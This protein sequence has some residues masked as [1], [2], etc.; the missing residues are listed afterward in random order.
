MKHLA[1]AS[2]AIQVR[3]LK[4]RGIYAGNG[5][6]IHNGIPSKVLPYVSH[7]HRIGEDSFV[8]QE[9]DR[10]KPQGCNQLIHHAVHAQHVQ[11][12]T[13]Q[14]NPGNE[15]RQVYQRLQRP[16]V[17]D[18]P[19]FIEQQGKNDRDNNARYNLHQCDEQ[20]V[21]NDFTEVWQ[22]NT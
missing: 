10:F 13:G 12:D 6:Q 9:V 14:C 3:S 22:G 20:R 8:A 4:Q 18:I 1:E 19:H 16:L 17:D 11:E 5:G 15:V 21:V 2:R 7:N